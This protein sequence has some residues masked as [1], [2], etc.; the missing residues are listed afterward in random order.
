M[1]C[2]YDPFRSG[3]RKVLQIQSGILGVDRP[4]KAAGALK[5]T[6]LIISKAWGSPAKA[7]SDMA[8]ELTIALREQG[9]AV[10]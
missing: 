7:A 5:E 3:L 4:F 6:G 9:Y 1:R 2:V 10:C 8:V